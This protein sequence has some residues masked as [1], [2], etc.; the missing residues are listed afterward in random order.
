[1][2]VATGNLP[3]STQFDCPGVPSGRYELEVVTN[4]I[5]GGT[6]FGAVVQP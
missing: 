3:V 2:G 1:M 5:S 6:L 4:G